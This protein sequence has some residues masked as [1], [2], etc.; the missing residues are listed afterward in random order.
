MQ[1]E[2]MA[3]N[4]L[5]CAIFI[6]RSAVELLHKICGLALGIAFQRNNMHMVAQTKYCRSKFFVFL[7]SLKVEI[8]HL[9]FTGFFKFFLWVFLN[10]L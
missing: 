3:L 2:Q 7:M 5:A 1:K 10:L 9:L 6:I 4:R 8:Y